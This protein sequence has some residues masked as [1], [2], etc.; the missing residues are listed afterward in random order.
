MAPLGKMINDEETSMQAGSTPSSQ[1]GDNAGNVHRST[2]QLQQQQQQQL[3]VDGPDVNWLQHLWQQQ[4]QQHLQNHQ[5]QH[6]HGFQLAPAQP[7]RLPGMP[8]NPPTT[9][10]AAAAEAPGA[11]SAQ[12]L[13]PGWLLLSPRQ[14]RFHVPAAAH[15]VMGQPPV[16]LVRTAASGWNHS[17]AAQSMQWDSALKRAPPG[18]SLLHNNA[19]PTGPPTQFRQAAFSEGA[20]QPVVTQAKQQIATSGLHPPAQIDNDG[21]SGA[22]ISLPSGLLAET[23]RP[24]PLRR[25]SPVP[26]A[27]A[28][29]VYDATRAWPPQL[30]PPHPT[31]QPQV[32]HAAP[33]QVAQGTPHPYA[34]HQA[35]QRAQPARPAAEPLQPNMG[36]PAVARS[37]AVQPNSVAAEASLRPLDVSRAPQ[38]RVWPGIVPTPLASHHIPVFT[39]SDMSW[40]SVHPYRQQQHQQITPAHSGLPGPPLYTPL[41]AMQSALNGIFAMVRP[42]AAVVQQSSA[43]GAAGPEI[44]ALWEHPGSL[45]Q[46]AANK[47]SFKP[48][49]CAVQMPHPATS[50]RGQQSPPGPQ[51][52]GPAAAATPTPSSPVLLAPQPQPH[53]P[54]LPLLP[55]SFS[56]T[57]VATPEA[58]CTSSAA[59]GSPTTATRKQAL[60]RRAAV[61][62]FMMDL[63]PEVCSTPAEN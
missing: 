39:G 52:M 7:L 33:T 23:P 31:Q 24:I 6:Q 58:R 37:S 21:T 44:P 26:K 4:H 27:A 42:G 9:A 15:G 17:T 1:A 30:M 10:A 63:P 16:S 57:A 45:S 28:D 29:A 3:T 40:Q 8:D 14:D 61:A 50:L 49:Q 32:M 46:P 59:R 22:H 11:P 5:Q 38:T 62:R 54:T 47:G 56:R 18:N 51:L 41:P 25:A 20:P 13:S 55:G 36:L 12:P 43:S 48:I 2:L 60:H 34:M 19:T 35:M 53:S